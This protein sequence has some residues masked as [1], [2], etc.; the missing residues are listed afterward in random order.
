MILAVESSLPLMSV[1]LVD[2]N[3]TLAAAAVRGE[4]SRNEKLLPAIDWLLGEAG[5]D[6]RAVEVFAVTRGPGSF[7]GLRIGLATVQGIARASG[8]PVCAVSTLHAAS[9]DGRGGTVLVLSDAGRGELYAAAYEEGG[10][11]LAPHVVTA[12]QALRLREEHA[13]LID[14]RTEGDD[15]NVALRTAKLAAKLRSGGDSERYSEA[16][17]LYVR[18][19]EPEAKLTS[20]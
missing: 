6:V 4:A 11:I 5:L 7:T 8:R 15:I 1:A 13:R 2:G 17:P 20:S 18:L 14:L 16:V 19:A 10:E 12:E 3:R 9:F